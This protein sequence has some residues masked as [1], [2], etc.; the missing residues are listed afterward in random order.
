MTAGAIL[1]RIVT[2]T[3]RDALWRTVVEYFAQHGFDRIIYADM[4]SRSQLILNSYP[5]SFSE[6]YADVCNPQDDPFFRYCCATLSPL[7]TGIDYLD[8]HDYLSRSERQVIRTAREAGMRS[9]FSCTFHK[10]D[11]AGMGGWNIGSTMARPEMEKIYAEHGANLRLMALYA[12]AR[13]DQLAHLPAASAAPSL[14]SRER[15]CL[16]YLAAGLR[17]Q[18]IA[19]RLGI[20]PVTVEMHVKRARGKLN[21]ATREQAVAKAVS[22]GLLKP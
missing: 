12:H 17:T 13:L 5:E 7:H 9:G 6:Y 11:H 1:D 16:A 10:V 3:T 18:Q 14:S 22:L 8:V 20:K 19:D 15:D 21:A 4:R 2:A